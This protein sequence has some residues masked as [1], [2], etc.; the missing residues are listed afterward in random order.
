MTRPTPAER[1]AQRAASVLDAVGG[2][3]VLLCALV[4]GPTHAEA[5]PA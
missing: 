4:T 1:A 5:V 2:Q 3:T